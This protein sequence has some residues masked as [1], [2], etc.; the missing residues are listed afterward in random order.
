M[1][2]IY[3]IENDFFLPHG[4]LKITINQ[5]SII[6][7]GAGSDGENSGSNKKVRTDPGLYH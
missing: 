7:V 2:R 1:H 6:T 3:L 4:W 5:V